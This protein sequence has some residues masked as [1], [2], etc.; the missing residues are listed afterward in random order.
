[1]LL[2]DRFK[3]PKKQIIQNRTDI[4]LKK[5]SGLRLFLQNILLHIRQKALVESKGFL[6]ARRATLLKNVLWHRCFPVSF[7]KL[8][9]IHF[10]TEDLRLLLL[11]MLMQLSALVVGTRIH[12]SCYQKGQKTP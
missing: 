12:L 5:S 3:K 8:L 1:M 7:A 9:R 4:S 10:L 2:L 11:D 6:Q